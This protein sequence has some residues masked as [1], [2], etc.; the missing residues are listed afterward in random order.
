MDSSGELSA[1]V[2]KVGKSLRV[3]DAR[4]GAT[5]V[6][7]RI[8]SDELKELANTDNNPHERTFLL[9]WEDNG[10]QWLMSEDKD[11]ASDAL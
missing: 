6:G 8:P 2:R 7:Q 11:A 9:C 4:N 3:F 5:A 1:A 10:I